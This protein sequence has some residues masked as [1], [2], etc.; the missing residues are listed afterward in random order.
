MR[1]YA[2]EDTDIASKS[3]LFS[4][5][6]ELCITRIVSFWVSLRCATLAPRT[7]KVELVT[8]FAG[9]IKSICRKAREPACTVKSKEVHR[10][11]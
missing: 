6:S 2:A 4:T 5:I 11:R 7:F 1:Y 9:A 10:G 8:T 3:A